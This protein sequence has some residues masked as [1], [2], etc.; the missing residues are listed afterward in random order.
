LSHL[1]IKVIPN[2]NIDVSHYYTDGEEDVKIYSAKFSHDDKYIAA[3]KYPP[4]YSPLKWNY[5]GLQCAEEGSQLHLEELA[6]EDSL[7]VHRLEAREHQLQDQ[8]H[9]YHCEL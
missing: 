6:E 5:H 1:R 9:P 8:E 3:G 7:L 4:E 2:S